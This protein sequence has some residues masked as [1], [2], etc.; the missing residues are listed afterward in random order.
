VRAVQT[1]RGRG[2]PRKLGLRAVAS[3]ACD[4][5]DHYGAKP[6]RAAAAALTALRLLERKAKASEGAAFQSPRDLD[7]VIS[8]MKAIRRHE[9]RTKTTPFEPHLEGRRTAFSEQKNEAKRIAS[10]PF[11][12]AQAAKHLG[13]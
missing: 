1:K 11:V 5:V 13:S 10:S 6:R 4:L 9:K 3:L 2:A 12:R 8:Q 7:D